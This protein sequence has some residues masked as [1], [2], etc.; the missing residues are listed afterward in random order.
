MCAALDVT[1]APITV[2]TCTADAGTLT[3]DA[4]P[5]QLAGASVTISATQDTAPTVP[6]NY[7]VVYVLTSGA[8]L[9]IEAI[10]ATPSFEVTEAGDYTI[11][12]LVAELD[13]ANDPNFLDASVV[14]PGVTT[15]VDVLTIVTDN[16]LCAALDVTGAP[17]TVQDPLSVNDN[18]FGSIKIV[19]NPV[20]AELSLLNTK[21]ILIQTIA[22]YDLTGR[23]VNAFNL[24]S[25]QT[26]ISI[27]LSHLSQ[28]NYVVVLTSDL[29][30]ISKQIIKM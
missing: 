22:V 28:G 12:T 4:T 3:A 8:G 18:V 11:H 13:D 15:G 1:G 20:V 30:S 25:N 7:E 17:I 2:E 6:A 29:G 10:G 19:S 24:N 27:E 5:V 21:N 23:V 26:S 16:G 14:V 9:V